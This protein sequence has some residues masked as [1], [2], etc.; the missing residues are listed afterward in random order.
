[1]NCPDLDM[2][3]AIRH[4]EEI[5]NNECEMPPSLARMLMSR[6]ENDLLA[7]EVQ[8]DD[9]DEQADVADAVGE[10]R[11]ERGVRVGF[12]LPP[13]PDQ[14][15][16]ADADELPADDHLQRVL[17]EHEEEHRGGE[18]RQEGEV[19]RVAAVAVHVVGRED[20]HEQRD[21]RDDHEH[22]HRLAVDQG[23]DRDR[24]AAVLEPGG[25]GDHRAGG[26]S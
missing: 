25:T 1:M 23:A 18:Q 12:L 19:V 3:A 22:E 8:G 4:N 13:V 2:T 17:G 6:I 14:R 26:R 9:A 11:L 20:V 24:L 16:G 15:E 7:G 21:Q 5:N 10:E